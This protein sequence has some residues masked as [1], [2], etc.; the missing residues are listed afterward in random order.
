MVV[1]GFF[2]L[3]IK[4]YLY[5]VAKGLFPL[6]IKKYLYMVAKGLFPLKIKKYLYIYIDICCIFSLAILLVS[7]VW[8][9]KRIYNKHFLSW[10]C[11]PHFIVV[12]G[13]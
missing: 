5:M 1:K 10:Y 9:K 12:A 8:P 7:Q 6:K 3:K 13:I 11:S 4:K 2:P